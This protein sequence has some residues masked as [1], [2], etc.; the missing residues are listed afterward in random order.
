MRCCL[1]CEVLEQSRLSN[2]GRTLLAGSET[3]AWAGDEK[4]IV[5][6]PTKGD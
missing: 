1:F 2:L 6:Q 4:G 3:E 5:E